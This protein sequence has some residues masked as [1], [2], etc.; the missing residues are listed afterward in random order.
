MLTV[1]FLLLWSSQNLC[2]QHAMEAVTTATFSSAVALPTRRLPTAAPSLH[3]LS[4]NRSSRSSPS[5]SLST[6]FLRS[7]SFL[8]GAGGSVSCDFYGVKVRPECMNPAIVCRSRGK[9]GVVTMVSCDTR[10]SSM[11]DLRGYIGVR[12]SR[13]GCYLGLFCAELGDCREESGLIVGF[14]SC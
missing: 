14:L 7:P 3:R 2:F 4:G 12:I 13:F 5:A 11:E 10:D 9:R 1:L 6:G 8:S